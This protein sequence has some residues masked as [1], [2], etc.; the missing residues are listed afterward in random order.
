LTK[1]SKQ[2]E[3]K[4][5]YCHLNQQGE[6]RW[7]QEL[8]QP[9]KIRH[10]YPMSAG[11]SLDSLASC[12]TMSATSV[13]PSGTVFYLCCMT[14]VDRLPPIWDPESMVFS[15]SGNGNSVLI[16]LKNSVIIC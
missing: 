7:L 5:E 10:L 12:T 4:P 2:A 9:I 1:L 13:A 16:V 14:G 3:Y 11:C 8:Q 15:A 6:Y